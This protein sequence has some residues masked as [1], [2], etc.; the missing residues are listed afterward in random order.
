MGQSVAR[1]GLDL[2]GALFVVAPQTSVFVNDTPA[3]TPA[4]AATEGS[5]T[6]FGSV[7]VASEVTVFVEDKKIAVEG[8][9]TTGAPIGK[10]SPNVFAGKGK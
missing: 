8:A 4:L 1:I 6:V 3:G 7:V 9:R 5:V 2:A 10:S